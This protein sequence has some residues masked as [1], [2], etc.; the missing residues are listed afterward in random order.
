MNRSVAVAMLAVAL[1]ALASAQRPV[2]VGPNLNAPTTPFS[3]EQGTTFIWQSFTIPTNTNHFTFMKLRF[4]FDG[5]A[6]G[7]KFYNTNAY[8]ADTDPYEAVASARQINQNTHGWVNWIIRNPGT[9][10][11]GQTFW[12][13]MVSDFTTAYIDGCGAGTIQNCT[14]DTAHTLVTTSD[15]YAGGFLA[16]ELPTDT[17]AVGDM[18]F[19]ATFHSTPEPATFVLLGTG[20]AGLALLRRPR[21]TSFRSE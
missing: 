18:L 8:Y 15:T 3:L 5:S 21:R 19:S 4:W 11:S 1:P 2:T 6:L 17:A 16:R 10:V 12:F 13:F 7:N 9:W 20:L 14:Y